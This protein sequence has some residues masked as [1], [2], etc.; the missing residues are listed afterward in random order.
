M[1]IHHLI[2]MPGSSILT[3][4]VR[5]S[6]SLHGCGIMLISAT[7]DAQVPD[8]SFGD[9]GVMSFMHPESDT[10]LTDPVQEESGRLIVVGYRD[11]VTIG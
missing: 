7:I 6:R 11:S 5:I 8:P 1:M 2:P 3:R 9:H 10:Y 4:T